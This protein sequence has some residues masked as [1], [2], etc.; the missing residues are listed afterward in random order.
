[1]GYR[2]L[3]DENIEQ[4]TITH[5]QQLDHDTEWIGDVAE[6]G[7]GVSDDV[8]AS[9][10]ARE[11]RLILTQDDD[12]LAIAANRPVGVLFQ[13]EETLSAREV[14][15]IVDELSDYIEQPDIVVE[16]VSRNWL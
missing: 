5:L 10:A 3:A 14:G 7:L 13:T 11:E 1:M 12:F 4:A 15:G 16:Y 9:Y 6:L 8:I 2:L